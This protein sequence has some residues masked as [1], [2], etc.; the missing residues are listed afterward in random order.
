MS[1]ANHFINKIEEESAFEGKIDRLY[2][3]LMLDMESTAE[4][5]VWNDAE[6]IEKFWDYIKY[7]LEKMPDGFS[8]WYQEFLDGY[9][10]FIINCFRGEHS[11]SFVNTTRAV[12]HDANELLGG[13]VNIP[14]EL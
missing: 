9:E 2:T 14:T 6:A 4:V 10:E 11:V 3:L 5:I 1:F 7:Q 8:K 12:L 13:T